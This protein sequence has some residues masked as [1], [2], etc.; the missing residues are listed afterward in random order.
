MFV[1]KH[2]ERLYFLHAIMSVVVRNENVF[3]N[4]ETSNRC[5]AKHL[6]YGWFWWLI[7]PWR[8]LNRYCRAY[9]EKMDRRKH[10]TSRWG[11]QAGPSLSTRR[12]GKAML[13]RIIHDELMYVYMVYG[14]IRLIEYEPG[15]WLASPSCVLCDNLY[16]KALFAVVRHSL[17]NAYHYCKLTWKSWSSL[18]S[19]TAL[20]CSYLLPLS[21]CQISIS[22]ISYNLQLALAR[23]QTAQHSNQNLR[24][25]L[26]SLHVLLSLT[27]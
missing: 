16:T 7:M 25:I 26:F 14:I 10:E 27:L 3:L 24:I 4:K 1:S 9:T 11:Q 6:F 22:V 12:A 8:Y 13:L 20:E 19:P 23:Q 15:M 17:Y 21:F 2:R 18:T 5:A